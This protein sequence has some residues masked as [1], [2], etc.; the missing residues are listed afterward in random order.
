MMLTA[1]SI[2]LPAILGFLILS[3]LFRNENE[4][5]FG[6]RLGMS[7]PVGAG[8]LTL[9]IFL[10]GVMRIPLTLRNTAMPVIIEIVFLGIF[11]FWKNIPIW[12]LISKPDSGLLSELMSARNHWAKKILLAIL[13]LWV[14]AKIGSIFFLTSLRPV[15]SWDA[16]A[17]WTTAAKM[18]F[19]SQSL[20]LDVP[21][22][23]FFG[24]SAVHRIIYYPLHNPLLQLWISLWNN[25][26]DDVFVKFCS[27]VYTLSATICLY[28]F[29]KREINCFIS[30]ALLVIFLSSPL[31]SYHSI[32]LNTDVMLGTTLLLASISFLKAMRGNSSYWFLTGL[33]SAESLFVKIQAILFVLPLILSALAMLKHEKNMP[34][35]NTSVFSLLIPFL[36]IM[37]WHIFV[38]YYGLGFFALHEWGYK[39]MMPFFGDDPNRINTYLTFHPEILLGY[40]Y[41]FFTLNNFNVI[42][43][44]SPILLIAH[45]KLTKESKHLLF[46]LILFMLSYI[47]LYIFTA[48]FVFFKWG[49]IFFR[50]ALTFYPTICLAIIILLKRYFQERQKFK[51]TTKE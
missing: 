26:F 1:I 33:L 16:W 19:Y 6:E 48:F 24:K 9:Q 49:V 10:L 47:F 18:F 17:E 35:R 40:M 22:Q 31:L 5:P 41:W 51:T 50:N 20:L 46:P 13:L 15:F 7:F 42:L 32:E 45:G 43:F 25:K 36:G 27:P 28:Y 4:T 23:D 39:T 12:P 21:A 11:M 3:V 14:I 34:L 37:P 44:F 2:I 29:C 30:L 8:I 38:Y